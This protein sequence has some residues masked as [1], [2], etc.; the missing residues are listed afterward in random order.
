M[1][2]FTPQN[3]LEELLVQAR[4]DIGARPAFY[5]AFLESALLVIGNTPNVQVDSSGHGVARLE[6]VRSLVQMQD[7]QGNLVIPVFSSVERLQDA[8]AGRVTCMQVKGRELL[9]L[10][11]GGRPLVLNPMS[12]YSKEFTP[13]ELAAL[14]DG[15]MFEDPEQRTY[16]PD[17][18]VLPGLPAGY[19][20]ALVGALKS[21]FARYPG[22]TRAYMVTIYSPGSAEPPH[23]VV[24]I[25][26]VSN[27]FDIVRDA[28][29]VTGEV[30][31]EGQYV[32]FLALRRGDTISDYMLRN[33]DPFYVSS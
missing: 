13:E 30:L 31:G 21:L 1:A 12:E 33:M 27:W 16:P 8:Q 24:G 22:I 25:D 17:V 15:S 14:Q 9:D 10:L 26:L 11:G 32:D 4:T 7:P 29:L 28:G 23:P 18:K 19:A 6:D 2:D 3:K 20:G 5:H